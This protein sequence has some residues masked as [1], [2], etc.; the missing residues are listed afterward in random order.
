MYWLC[1]TKAIQPVR[2]PFEHPAISTDSV[3]GLKTDWLTGDR[4]PEPAHPCLCLPSE[5]RLQKRQ[6]REGRVAQPAV[7]VI[8]ISIDAAPLGQRGCWRCHNSAS[9]IGREACRDSVCP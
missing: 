4:P 2:F 5:A 1:A 8:P 9:E 3:E 6:Q 7:T